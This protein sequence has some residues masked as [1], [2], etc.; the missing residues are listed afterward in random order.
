M[1]PV[2][3]T[4][5]G[6]ATTWLVHCIAL[7]LAF[8]SCTEAFI[9]MPGVRPREF[10]DGQKVIL[11]AVKMTSTKTQLPYDYYYLNFCEPENLKYSSESLGEVLLGDRIANLPHELAMRKNKD[12]TVLCHKTLSA[13]DIKEFAKFI[14]N[15]YRVHWMTDSLP[16][17]MRF[18]NAEGREVLFRGFPLG[19]VNEAGLIILYNHVDITLRYHPHIS[20]DRKGQAHAPTTRY[21][22]VGFEIT[23]LSM[24]E[25]A[26][27]ANDNEPCLPGSAAPYIINP[28]ADR[29]QE[30]TFTYAIKWEMVD[31]T[32]AARWDAYLLSGD[33]GVHWYSIINSILVV[34]FLSG[35][36]AVIIVRTLRRDIARYNEEDEDL[37]DAIDETGWKL[38]HGDVFRPP[39]HAGLLVASV[40]VGMQ[41]LGMLLG[42]LVLSALGML[43][44]ASNNG[45]ISLALV[46][47]GF[48]GVF[49]GYHA[50]RFYK[51]MKGKEWHRT[52][53]LTGTLYP[54]IAIGMY[55]MVD[56]VLLSKQSSGAVPFSS[57]VVILL[58][59][60]GLSLPLVYAGFYF[61]YRKK[62]IEAPV[63]TNQIPRQVPEQPL[64]LRPIPSMMLAGIFPF[65]AVFIELFFVM[66][67]LWQGTFYYLFGFLFI[68]FVILIVTCAE[69]TIVMVYFHL[70]AEDYHWWWPSFMTS[71]SLAVYVLLYAIVY[72]VT[73]LDIDTMASTILYFGYTLIMVSTFWFMTG[74]VGFLATFWF[75]RRI[76]GAVKVD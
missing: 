69:I 42:V 8:V 6:S 53:L 2:R 31:A 52:A 41:I 61:G 27:A 10:D 23:P 35:I 40:G 16:G 44:P 34:I 24:E 21:R 11:Q 1:R 15:E 25:K 26:Q 76:Y 37:E 50:A 17:A 64:Y 38:V 71:G 75:V 45:Q 30:I 46:L 32:W 73:R 47:F 13:D 65:G 56:F 4:S 29:E 39:R 43:S 36:V 5:S 68:V 72:Y 62:A 66:S 33:Q 18:R 74:A 12:C 3:S 51:T 9:M 14:E 7:L 48:M 60:L 63:R 20:T 70:C 28:N 55:L 67:S 49:S 19:T 59:W 58:S 22:I 57:F 54:A